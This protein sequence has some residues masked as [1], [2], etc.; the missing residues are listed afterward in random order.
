MAGV[1][2]GTALAGLFPT[3]AVITESNLVA[4][5]QSANNSVSAVTTVAT[6]V[7]G[8]SLNWLHTGSVYSFWL[9]GTTTAQYVIGDGADTVLV[10]ASAVPP[11][12]N[13]QGDPLF[14]MVPITD[15]AG[16]LDTLLIGWVDDVSFRVGNLGAGVTVPAGYHVGSHFV[17]VL[18]AADPS[19]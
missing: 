14:A 18:G 7:P 17:L 1:V 16:V 9:S 12:A 3:G 19:L 11:L 15:S 13:Y 6:N 5:I 10:A 4:F 8:V 2:S